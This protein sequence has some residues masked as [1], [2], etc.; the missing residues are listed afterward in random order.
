M[1]ILE[2]VPLTGK[3][4]EHQAEHFKHTTDVIVVDL[5]GFGRS[6]RVRP[7]LDL[8]VRWLGRFVDELGLAPAALAGNCIGSLAALH[9][10]ARRPRPYS[11][12]CC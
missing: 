3:L 11:R 2:S 5:P 1:V 7:T 4:W 8:Y 12:S 6:D 9:Y 10:A